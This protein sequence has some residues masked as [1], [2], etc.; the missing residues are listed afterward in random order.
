MCVD[1]FK[2]ADRKTKEELLHIHAEGKKWIDGWTQLAKKFPEVLNRTNDSNKKL[3]SRLV[4]AER[5]GD[6]LVLFLL[7]I[8]TMLLLSL[9]LLSILEPWI[10]MFTTMFT[11][12]FTTITTMFTTIC[13]YLPYMVCIYVTNKVESNVANKDVYMI[14]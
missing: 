5:R 2:Q 10:A 9:L 4:Y 13:F 14:I 7:F 6:K 12:V 3:C 11:T 8:T 1:L